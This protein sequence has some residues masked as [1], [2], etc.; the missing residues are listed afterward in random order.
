MCSLHSWIC[1]LEGQGSKHTTWQLS[2]NGGEQ[3]DTCVSLLYH[4][5]DGDILHRLIM[6]HDPVLQEEEERHR[7]RH[8]QRGDDVKTHRGEPHDDGG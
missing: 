8:V 2:N 4:N 7:D 1:Y 3:I 5:L 6:Q